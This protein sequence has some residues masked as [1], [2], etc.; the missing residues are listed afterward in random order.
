MDKKQQ[1]KLK[2]FIKN[3]EKVRGRH[4]E[5]VSV[6]VPA[7]YD[8]NKIIGHIKEEQGT[9]SNIKDKTTR[10]NVI[11]SLERIIRHLRLFKKTPDNGLAIFAGNFS[12]KESQTDIQVH[13]IEPSEPL[14]FRLYR[15]DQTFVLDALKDMLDVHDTYGLLVIDNREANVGTLRGTVINQITHMTS[16]VPGKTRAGG[17]SSVRFARLREIAA[18]DFYKRIAEIANKEFASANIKGILLGGPGFTKNTFY[19]GNY[20]NENVKRKVLALKDLS[21]TGEF[22][23]NELV[24]KSHDT[25]A[26]LPIM[27]E[28]KLVAD[29]FEMIA[30]SS[31]KAIYGLAKVKYALELGAVD[32]LLLS[33]DLEDSL[34]EE[35]EDMAE[36]TSSKVE[37][38]STDTPEGK[39][40][41]EL[42]KVGAILRFSL[43]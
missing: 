30:K 34:I 25:L 2:A 1:H 36:K 43:K 14:N 40:F 11:D 7:G 3:L 10:N 5:L 33:D 16:G 27:K 6:Y 22:G 15:C 35:L 32:M 21:Y 38:I 4:T 41:M 19:D 26:E 42:G 24:D 13:S 9:A 29:F 37:L 31:D 12:D 20:L 23:L 39:Q 8:L 17:Q 28:K 18:H